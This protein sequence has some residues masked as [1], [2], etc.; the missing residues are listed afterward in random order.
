M[1]KYVVMIKSNAVSGKEAEYEDWY[2]NTHLEEVLQVPGFV[3]GQQFRVKPEN[4]QDAPVFS[5]LA[6]FEVESEDIDATLATLR[7]TFMSGA[8][9]L[10][11]AM[12]K[13]AGS[14]RSVYQV[15]GDEQ[16]QK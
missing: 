4:G 14:Q 9:T 8:M 16:H 10:T 12:D 3:S 15:T 6:R 13:V 11:D 5:H 2:N 7:N 1:E